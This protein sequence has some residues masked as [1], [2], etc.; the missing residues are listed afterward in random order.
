MGFRGGFLGIFHLQIIRE[1]LKEE[2]GLDVLTTM[3]MTYRV[4][5]K[6]EDE[7]IW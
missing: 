6:N 1:R 5:V 7:P 4:M 2:F 3:L